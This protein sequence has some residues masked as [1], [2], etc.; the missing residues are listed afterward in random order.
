MVYRVEFSP[1]ADDHVASLKAHQRARLLDAIER[2]LAHQPTIETRHRKPL[3]PNAVAQYRLRIGELRVY[4]DVRK[5]PDNVV[6]VK[7]VGVK[8]RNR[9]YVGGKEIQL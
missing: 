9:I 1:E 4:Y 8:V 6:I 2:Q 3:R 7:A 5:A